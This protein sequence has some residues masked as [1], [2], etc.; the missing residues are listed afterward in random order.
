MERNLL[1]IQPLQTPSGEII[2]EY[3]GSADKIVTNTDP[4]YVPKHSMARI[5]IPVGKK[6]EKH[7]HPICEESYTI[8]SGQGYVTIDNDRHDVTEGSS[9]IIPP[10]ARHQIFNTGN[11]S[12]IFFAVCI[13]P[14]T[15][16]CSVFEMKDGTEKR[17]STG[18]AFVLY[19][20]KEDAVRAV[21]TYNGQE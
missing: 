21:Q 2:H 1:N 16:D 3:F 5:E 12:L 15:A 7:F 20:N 18:V 8:I 11:N 10:K 9:V 14:W 13:P 17:R 4:N 6:S 19:L